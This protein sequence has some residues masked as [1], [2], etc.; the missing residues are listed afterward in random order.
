MVI[1]TTPALVVPNST[2]KYNDYVKGKLH[3]NDNDLHALKGVKIALMP[4]QSNAI[5]RRLTLIPLISS[6]EDV[7][8]HGNSP[9]RP[10]PMIERDI[11]TIHINPDGVVPLAAVIMM[12]PTRIMHTTAISPILRPITSMSFPNPAFIVSNMTVNKYQTRIYLPN[13]PIR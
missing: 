12:D 11:I 3:I 2:I 10:R 5:P 8:L 6:L 7:A 13:W 9:P 1:V 4:T